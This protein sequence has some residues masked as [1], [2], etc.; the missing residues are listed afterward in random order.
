VPIASSSSPLC[1]C[2]YHPESCF[3]DK[4]LFDQ[5]AQLAPHQGHEAGLSFD[6]RCWTFDVRCSLWLRP[7]AALCSFVAAF[8]PVGVS[9]LTGTYESDSMDRLRNMRYSAALKGHGNAAWGRATASPQ[10]A[11][12]RSACVVAG[13]PADLRPAVLS[14]PCSWGDAGALP[15]AGFL[16]PVGPTD[17]RPVS[18]NVREPYPTKTPAGHTRDRR[19]VRARDGEL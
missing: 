1:S 5:E 7:T 18:G 14:V 3:P 11:G 8:L 12:P 4:K 9:E 2:Y 6:V 13:L 17:L 16:W 19:S 10:E 15:Q